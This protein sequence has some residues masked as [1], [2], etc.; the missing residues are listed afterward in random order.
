MEN[1]SKRRTI[2]SVII[3]DDHRANFETLAAHLDTVPQSEFEMKFFCDVYT[4]ETRDFP[5]HVCGSVGCAL[6][7][8]PLIGFTPMPDETWETYANRCFGAYGHIWDWVF[9][10]YWSSV[11]NTPK[12]T[13]ARI[14]TMLTIGIPMVYNYSDGFKSIDEDFDYSLFR[15]PDPVKKPTKKAITKAVAALGAALVVAGCTEKPEILPS[16]GEAIHKKEV[17]IPCKD[18]AMMVCKDGTGLYAQKDVLFLFPEANYVLGAG[19]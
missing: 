1:T 15:T 9:G 12:G 7:K 19:A 8:A 18:S 13:A 11:D 5:A 2:E 6:G 3:L 17:G 14:R 16:F 10:A 4:P